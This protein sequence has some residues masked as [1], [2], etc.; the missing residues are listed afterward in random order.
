MLVLKPRT[1]LILKSPKKVKKLK[2]LLAT[3]LRFS[4]YIKTKTDLKVM[5]SI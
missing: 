3:L 5:I 1:K 2:V 4:I